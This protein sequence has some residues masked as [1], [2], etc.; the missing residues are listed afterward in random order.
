MSTCIAGLNPDE[1]PELLV[2]IDSHFSASNK[3]MIDEQKASSN[4][5][6]SFANSTTRKLIQRYRHVL[7]IKKKLI[8]FFVMVLIQLIEILMLS[9]IKPSNYFYIKSISNPAT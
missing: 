4:K 5:T 6:A 3:K 1:K 7:K 8:A 2:P 9:L